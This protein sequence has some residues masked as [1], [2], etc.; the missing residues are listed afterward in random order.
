MKYLEGNDLIW[1]LLSIKT[2]ASGNPTTVKSKTLCLDMTGVKYSEDMKLKNA[3][4]KTMSET[5][6]NGNVLPHKKSPTV[7][8][9][10]NR[11]LSLHDLF[12]LVLD[13]D[14]QSELFIIKGLSS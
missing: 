9:C 12:K 8:L 1:I 6:L 14:F 11:G 3:F 2:A 4:M 7:T 13:Q 10:I 5:Y